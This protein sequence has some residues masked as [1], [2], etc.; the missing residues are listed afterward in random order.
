[1]KNASS[2]FGCANG[3]GCI[4]FRVKVSKKRTTASLCP[5]ENIV[6]VLSGKNIENAQSQPAAVDNDRPGQFAD[7]HEW[8]ENTSKY[9]F[10]N[11]RLDTSDSNI[12]YLQ[13]RVMERNKTEDWSSVH[14]VKGTLNLICLFNCVQPSA[15]P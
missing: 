7:Q 9:L 2:N 15:M 10:E 13:Q 12:R 8:L 5:H 11:R 3:S 1:M 4:R 14:Q 6:M